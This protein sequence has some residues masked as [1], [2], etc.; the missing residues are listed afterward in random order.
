MKTS[1][2]SL[3]P[4]LP[5]FCSCQFRGFNST[6][7][8]YSSLLLQLPLLCLVFG[9][10]LYHLGTDH[11]ENTARNV[12][13]ACLPRRCLAIDVLLFHAFASAGMC[14]A[15]RCVAMGMHVTIQSHCVFIYLW[16][17][18]AMHPMAYF[19]EYLFTRL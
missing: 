1:L 9:A 4:F 13:E 14:L 19:S 7:F 2:H 3:I 6:I 16:R 10:L 5:L 18:L 11:T 12:D 8:D 15:S 17:V